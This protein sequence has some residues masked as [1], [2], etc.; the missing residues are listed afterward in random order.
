MYV[1]SK[2]SRN[3]TLKVVSKGSVGPK[4]LLYHNV[5]VSGDQRLLKNDIC[6]PDR[7]AADPLVRGMS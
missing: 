5:K 3:A 2:L 6:C 7:Y 4:T 1:Y